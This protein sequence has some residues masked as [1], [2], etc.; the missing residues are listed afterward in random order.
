ML[1]ENQLF[2]KPDK[3]EFEQTKV[4]YLGVIISHNSDEMD[5]VKVAGVA[6][7]PIPNNKK[8][9][10]SFLGFINFYR[11]FVQD[12]SHHAHP[13]F[14]LTKNDVKWLWSQE[15]QSAFDTLKSLVTSAPILT[16]PDNSRPFHIEADS[17]DFATRAVL[18][19]ESVIDRKW[20]PVAFLSKSLSEVEQNYEIHDKEMLAIIRAMEEWRHFLEGSELGFEV[21]TDHKN[22]EYFRTAKK[23]NRRQARWSLFLARFDFVLHHR[24]GKSMGKPNALSRR[25]DHGTRS[26]DNSNI[27][28]LTPGLF[29]VCALEG[30][31]VIGEERD[32]LRDIQKGT[33]DGEPE[34]A[35]AKVVKDLKATRS[36]TIRSAEWTLID[37]ILY[38]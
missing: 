14:N 6:E 25:A 1:E 23:L 35:I 11:R 27:T 29:A 18:S 17:S 30:L 19:Q 32:I 3:C 36:R 33:R 38:F 8:E 21:W 34:E 2:L 28:L 13:L 15:E 4:E 16:S 37:H 9:V 12:F 22:L 26:D 24:P 10:Q 20:H 5:L 31:E 7:W